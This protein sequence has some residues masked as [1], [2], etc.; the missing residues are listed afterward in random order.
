MLQQALVAIYQ[1]FTTA[2]VRVLVV[3]CVACLLTIIWTRR[4]QIGPR[5][6]HFT[7]PGREATLSLL[8]MAAILPLLFVG[9]MVIERASDASL[10]VRFLVQILAQVLVASPAVVALMVRRQGAV[11]VG[12]SGQ[13]LPKLFGLGVCLSVV[14]VLL[15]TAIPAPGGSSRV[16]DEPLTVQRGIYL[17]AV[18]AVSALGHEFIYRGYL[19]TRLMAWAGEVTGLLLS[20][21]V[22]ALFHL[23][24]FLGVYNAL[25]ILVQMIG[26]FVLGLVLGE[27]RRRSGSIIPSAFF[28]AASDSALTLL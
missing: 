7:S 21:L 20:A 9:N 5:Q 15:F 14:T 12:L 1:W 25:T 6:D 27:I 26:L 3:W 18:F 23:P 10:F 24:R 13:N 17:V 11:T 8:V 2:F 16:Q 4:A 28:H 19:Q 22:Y